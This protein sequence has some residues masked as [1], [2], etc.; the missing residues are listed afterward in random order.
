MS[1][2]PSEQPNGSP[3]SGQP[4]PPQPPVYPGYPPPQ[5]QYPGY[6]PQ[7]PVQTY[8]PPVPGYGQQQLVPPTY[9][10]YP[11]QPGQPPYGMPYYGQAP[12]MQPI[13]KESNPRATPALVWGIIG[14]A[15]SILTFVGVFAFA[16]AITGGYAIY[17][18]VNALNYAN[19]LPGKT[20]QAQGIIGLIFGILAIL[21]V[22]GTLLLRAAVG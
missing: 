14:L 13:V 2:P 1:Q 19:R 5:P 20:G 8:A 4:Y 15:L 18:S 3:Q 12:M 9:P 11:P 7:P 10:G 21:I 16:G 17:Y 6:L 22:I